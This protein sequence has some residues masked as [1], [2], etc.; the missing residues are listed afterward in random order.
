MPTVCRP[1]AAPGREVLL[2]RGLMI[3]RVEGDGGGIDHVGRAPRARLPGPI[4]VGVGDHL[5]GRWQAVRGEV[6]GGMGVT[7]QQCVVAADESA[8]ERRAECKRRSVRR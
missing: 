1:A 2:W 5:V 3:G 4:H 8:V 7:H 6:L